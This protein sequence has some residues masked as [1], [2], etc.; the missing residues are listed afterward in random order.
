MRIRR[1]GFYVCPR[2][3]YETISNVKRCPWCGY[4]EK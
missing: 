1:K 4:T 2:C 3:G